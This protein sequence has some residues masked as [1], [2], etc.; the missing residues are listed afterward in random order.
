MSSPA[1]VVALIALLAL[2]GCGGSDDREPSPPASAKDFH[3]LER[4]PLE[5]PKFDLPGPSIEAGGVAGRCLTSKQREVGALGLPR[6]P[7]EAG[8]GPGTTLEELRRGPVYVVMLEGP[9]R[10]VQLPSDPP[11]RGRWHSVKTIWVSRSGYDGPVLI[12][13]GRL[14]QAGRLRFGPGLQSALRLPA[15]DWPVA[16]THTSGQR[17]PLLEGWRATSVPT[18]IRDPG[19]Y[20]FQVDGEG[21]SYVLPF[22]VQEY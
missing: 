2:A 8:L 6:V 3:V 10:I 7:G 20:A 9:P 15:D 13:G 16:G 19:C 18:R 12:R 1:A 4:R 22:G 21:F 5:L 14:E 11:K 17:E